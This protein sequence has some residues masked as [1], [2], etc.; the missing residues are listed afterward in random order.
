MIKTLLSHV[1]QYKGAALLTPV[2]TTAEVVMGV[3]IPYVTASLIDK[4]INAGNMH[5]V[6]RYGGLMLLM[7]AFST[8]SESSPPASR[9]IPPAALPQTFGKRCTTTYSG[10]PSPT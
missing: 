7:A 4:G 9:H 5:E 1:R 3:L 10:S 6:Y 8:L 2:W